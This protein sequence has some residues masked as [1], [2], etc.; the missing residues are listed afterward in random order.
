MRDLK[1]VL[2]DWKQSRKFGSDITDRQLV[3]MADDYLPEAIN[4]A[5]AAEEKLA[6]KGNLLNDY[7]AA[8]GR[9]EE[10]NDLQRIAIQNLS[11]QVVALRE[12][13]K[14]I[15][16]GGGVDDNGCFIQ[17]QEIAAK[18]LSSPDPG[19]K[20]MAVV[21]AAREIFS[22]CFPDEEG[23][24][25]CEGRSCDSDICET[26]SAYALMQALADLEGGR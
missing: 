17:L 15:K 23:V 5:I 26:C 21:E 16:N 18:L 1:A 20:V 10:E 24:V 3:Y 22:G 12:G 25:K 8:K 13:L 6:R 11:C 7:K 9:L 2:E 14:K 19:E 4:R